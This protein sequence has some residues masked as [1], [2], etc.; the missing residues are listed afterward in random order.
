MGGEICSVLCDGYS[1]QLFGQ[2][3]MFRFHQGRLI[4]SGLQL[5]PFRVRCHH[6]PAWM[7]PHHQFLN[8]AHQRLPMHEAQVEAMV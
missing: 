7:K 3:Q 2:S 4:L 5:S 1:S 8:L 6:R